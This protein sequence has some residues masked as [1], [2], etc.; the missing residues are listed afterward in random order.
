MDETALAKALKEG[1][2][3]GAALDVFSAEPLPADNPLRSAPNLL[4][5]PH[6]AS[7]ARET[8][9]ASLPCGGAVDC[10]FDEGKESPMGSRPESLRIAKA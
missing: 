1:W 7:F 5:T 8:G 2:I 6:L 4:L 10:G 9:R 3:A